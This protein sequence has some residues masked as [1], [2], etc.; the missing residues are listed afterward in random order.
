M[1]PAADPRRGFALLMVFVMA[2]TICIALYMAAPKVAFEAQRAKEDMLIQRGEQYKRAIQLFVRKSGGARYPATLDD[3]EN[4]N[5]I[6]FLR[7]RYKDPMTGKD[8]WRLIHVGPGGVLTDSKVN[9][10]KGPADKDEKKSE[11][12]FITEGPAMTGSTQ[13]T[14][15]SAANLAL[16]QRPSDRAGAAGS[17][18]SAPAYGYNPPG[19]PPLGPDGQ[20]LPQPNTPFQQP[21]MP[22]FQ[23]NAPFQ[24]PGIAPPQG[25]TPFQQAG[26]YTPP[27]QQPGMYVPPGQQPGM[28]MQPGQQP[29]MP[30]TQ[31]PGGM[32]VIGGMV[33]SPTPGGPQPSP[34]N[35]QIPGMP[36]VPGAPGGPNPGLDIIQRILTTPRPGGLPGAAAS[37]GQIIG[38]GIAG[39]ATK[40]EGDSIKIYKDRQKYDEWEFIYDIKEDLQKQMPGGQLP[41]GQNPLGA[42]PSTS[43]PSMTPET[44]RSRPR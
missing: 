29:G 11:N 16:R 43:S 6:R 40:Y 23:G 35:P 26:V 24:Q 41:Q 5:G 20:P 30:G 37:A 21:G 8:E 4:T 31:P 33:T 3:L 42:K 28:Y 36:G 22:N 27:G 10:Q 44:P 18:P 13:Q 2:A 39:V 19:V 9:K 14:P 32:Y 25:S 1:N 17:N 38:G 34:Y 15:G 7:R 12:T